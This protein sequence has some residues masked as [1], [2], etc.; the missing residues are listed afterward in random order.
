MTN[1]E[2]IHPD[3]RHVLGLPDKERIAFMR[4]P[5][6]VGY[7]RAVR[8]LDTLRDLMNQPPRPRM[9]SLLIVGEPNNG[10]TTIIRRFQDLFGRGYVNED[11]DPVKPVVVAEAPPSADEKG[12][13][14]SIL[15]CFHPSYRA[16]APA[17]KLRYQ[18]TTWLQSCHVR[19]IVIDEFHSLLTGSSREQRKAMNAIKFICNVAAVP[20]IG[21]GTREAVRVLHTD[22]QHASRFDVATLPL[23]ELNKD[24]Q[25]LLASF[26][27][28]LPLRKPSGLHRQELAIPLHAISD[29]NLGNL[30]R[31]LTECAAEAIKSGKEQIDKQI[32]E[33]KAWV[34]PTKGIREIAA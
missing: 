4:E 13:Y 23:W 9:Q 15:E 28:I 5:R 26:E 29:G 20:I 24:F 16:S 31:L 10:K 17:A 30:H 14:I 6:W 18:T 32:I 2:H 8:I 12:L 22:E 33:S 19:I 27:K 11:A 1:A 21:V 34:R 25:R 7:E 3:L